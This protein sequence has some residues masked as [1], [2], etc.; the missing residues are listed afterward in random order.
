M[1][2][3]RE[4]ERNDRNGAEENIRPVFLVHN[5][6]LWKERTRAKVQTSSFFGW[7]DREKKKLV[8]QDQR[9]VGLG[10]ATMDIFTSTTLDKK[11]CFPRKRF[12]NTHTTPP[13]NTRNKKTER[14]YAPHEYHRKR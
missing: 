11:H 2:N 9:K 14:R 3:R 10:G 7:G 6:L 8:Q 1:N 13:H 12:K 5:D 4:G